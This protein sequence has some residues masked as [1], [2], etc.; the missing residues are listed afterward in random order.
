M[1]VI[2][3][4]DVV[5]LG[6]EGDVKEVARG[7]ARNFLIPKELAVPYNKQTLAMFESRRAQIEKRKQ[8]KLQLAQSV[9]QRIEG[10]S[11]SISMQAGEQGKLF[12]SVTATTI[13]DELEKLGITVERKK[14]DIPDHTI[15]SSGS[16]RV[17]I[18]LYGTEEATLRVNVNQSPGEKKSADS[19]AAGGEDN[20]ASESAAA[21]SEAPPNRSRATAAA[22]NVETA[23][24]ADGDESA[25]AGEPDADNEGSHSEE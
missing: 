7:Y 24:T 6:E 1:K 8:E 9:K 19:S 22:G 3:N 13:A 20:N 17:R 10:T 15:K 14:V 23:V 2:L 12:G 16:Y 11:L 4:N 21:G 18:R 5:N 25:E